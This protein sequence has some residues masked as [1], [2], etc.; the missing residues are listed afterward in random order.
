MLELNSSKLHGVL[1]VETFCVVSWQL[2][3]P[4]N[5]LL[6]MY[7]KLSRKNWRKAKR[8][9]HVFLFNATC[10]HLTFSRKNDSWQRTLSNHAFVCLTS[11]CRHSGLPLSYRKV[12]IVK[13]ASLLETEQL[14][15]K[16]SLQCGSRVSFEFFVSQFVVS[17]RVHFVKVH[18]FFYIRTSNFGAGNKP[19]TK[20]AKPV[21]TATI[22]YIKGTS[23]TI[24]RILQPYNIRVA[25]KPIT[26][27]R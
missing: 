22:P 10:C 2:E 25:H 15:V 16:S 6:E 12:P 8:Y 18:S 9:T 13:S 21:T 20:N 17:K 27:L 7:L 23:E 19:N 1:T 11:A 5:K 14:T 26:T 4:E 3:I 24:A